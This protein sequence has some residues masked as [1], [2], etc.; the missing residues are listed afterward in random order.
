MTGTTA[1]EI[2]EKTANGEPVEP[3]ENSETVAILPDADLVDA[4]L[5]SV[6]DANKTEREQGGHQDKDGNIVRWDQGLPFDENKGKQSIEQWRINGKKYYKYFW[7]KAY[8][9]T[10]AYQNEYPDTGGDKISKS[11]MKEDAEIRN[12]GYNGTTFVTGGRSRTVRFYH[13]NK[14]IGTVKLNELQRVTR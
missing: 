4:V 1:E 10:H 14:T 7:V 12:A 5:E 3:M 8:W 13:K 11:D 2:K 9:H 6:V